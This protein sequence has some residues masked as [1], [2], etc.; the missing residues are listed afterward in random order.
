MSRALRSR[1]PSP[2]PRRR[3]FRRLAPLA[4]VA[5]A[6]LAAPYAPA[7]AAT[8]TV[9][10]VETSV[11]N[12]AL[13]TLP[14][15]IVAANENFPYNGCAAG[16]PTGFDDIVFDLPPGATI[17]AT[18]APLPAIRSSLTISGPGRDQLVID[19]DNLQ[20]LFVVETAAEP[21]TVQI[22]DLTLTRGHGQGP[23]R[24]GA[25]TVLA[26]DALVVRRV[27]FR[28][29]VAESGGGALRIVGAAGL[30]AGTT[31]EDC[32]FEGNEAGA[33][34][35][36]AIFLDR[37]IAQVRR[38]TFF[39][40]ETAAEPSGGVARGG[41]AIASYD[42]TLNVRTSTFYGNY[43]F[44]SGGA[45]LVSSNDPTSPDLLS[46][47]DS[48]IF[49]NVGDGDG[50][51]LGNVGGVAVAVFPGDPMSVE[52]QNTL[53]AKNVDPGST[54]LPDL[55]VSGTGIESLG[56]NLVG[57]NAGIEF[58]FP[59]G[60]PNV[61]GDYVGTVSSPLHPSLGPFDFWGGPT[62]VLPPLATGSTPVID[63]GHCWDDSYDQRGFVDPATNRRPVDD[64]A[65]P[66]PTGGDG[67]DIGAVEAGAGPPDTSA[68]FADGFET[69]DTIRWSAV[70]P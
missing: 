55:F 36:G 27:D 22:R 25:V 59:A 63:L 1:R 8:I 13:C 11:V 38:S 60:G 32:F 5:V 16:S 21:I 28:H 65:F 23:G 37:A 31:V 39:T 64:P 50:D 24:G 62:P 70:A 6:A 19:G 67:C 14:E 68:I 53:I 35:G 48:T 43:T 42:S 15:A 34:G 61:N 41:G 20:P 3:P 30:P 17:T 26:G 49:E 33:G 2:A 4:L 29:N 7:L 51:D 66:E 52:V 69:G 40:N 18:I 12:D 10:S 46:I 57:V 47:T 54:H 58:W 56:H 44:G 45:L 9:D